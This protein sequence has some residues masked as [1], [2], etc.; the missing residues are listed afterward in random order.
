MRNVQPQYVNRSDARGVREQSPRGAM[1][2][3]RHMWHLVLP[4]GFLCPVLSATAIQ[5]HTNNYTSCLTLLTTGMVRLPD[6]TS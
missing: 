2:S 5:A 3:Q 4:G 6:M 1:S